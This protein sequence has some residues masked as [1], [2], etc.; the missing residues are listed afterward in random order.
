VSAQNDIVARLNPKTFVGTKPNCF[1]EWQHELLNLGKDQFSLGNEIF[2]FCCYNTNAEREGV[3]IMATGSSLNSRS[4]SYVNVRSRSLFQN[5]T[6][7]IR[8]VHTHFCLSKFVWGKWAS[9]PTAFLEA[10]L[11]RFILVTTIQE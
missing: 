11:S 5:G 2:S 6:R 1:A 7:E 10:V 4:T 9:K 3:V 8:V